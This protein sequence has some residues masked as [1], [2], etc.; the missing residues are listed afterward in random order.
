[1]KRVEKKHQIHH[2]TSCL[3]GRRK[4]LKRATEELVAARLIEAHG[5]LRHALR[6]SQESTSKL[7]NEL[8]Q[9]RKREAELQAEYQRLKHRLTVAQTVKQ[10]GN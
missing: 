9:S 8:K 5:Q 7:E 6:L 1:M 3:F 2:A 4:A 10:F